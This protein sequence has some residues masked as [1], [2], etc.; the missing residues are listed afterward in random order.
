MMK[1]NLNTELNVYSWIRKVA[2]SSNIISLT[3]ICDQKF[4]FEGT[5]NYTLFSM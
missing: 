4:T 2:W 3:Y 1:L 5:R